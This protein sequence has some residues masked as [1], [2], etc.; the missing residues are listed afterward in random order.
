[1]YHCNVSSDIIE[2]N[3]VTVVDSLAE[4]QKMVYALQNYEAKSLGHRK[5][6]KI[7]VLIRLKPAA[8]AKNKVSVCTNNAHFFQS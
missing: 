3:M 5:A 6:E 1:M 2:H 8:I 7:R 4:I